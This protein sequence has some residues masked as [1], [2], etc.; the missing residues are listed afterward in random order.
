ME[1]SRK[2]AMCWNDNY[3]S[4]KKIGCR[5]CVMLLSFLVNTTGET[6]F[7][8][9]NTDAAKWGLSRYAKTRQLRK[10]A[11]A[12]YI[13]LEEAN[14]RSP[15]VTVLIEMAWPNKPAYGLVAKEERAAA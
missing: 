7:S 12:G 11:E 3:L 4:A 9:T 14:G 8:V 15:I 2:F 1:Q 5:D 13:L 6:R 10:M